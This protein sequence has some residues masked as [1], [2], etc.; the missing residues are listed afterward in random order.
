M[1]EA[2]Q[3]L[4][5]ELDHVYVTQPNVSM[6]ISEG[7]LKLGPREMS[8]RD[9]DG[10]VGVGAIKVV[11]GM[12]FAQDVKTA[13]FDSIPHH[14]ITF[15]CVDKVL[16]AAEIGRELGRLAATFSRQEGSTDGVPVL[17][18]GDLRAILQI[19]AHKGVD[20]SIQK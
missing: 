18:G 15:S 5:V 10:T 11:G 8:G 12:K 1:L 19:C 14:A 6:R 9:F 2:E 20:Y 4:E 7:R 16:P 3:D 13:K 17:Q